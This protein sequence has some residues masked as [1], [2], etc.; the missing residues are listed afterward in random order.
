MRME[1]KSM[2]RWVTEA[3]GAQFAGASAE[4]PRTVME[5]GGWKHLSIAPCAMGW[6]FAPGSFNS[7]DCLCLLS[8]IP[9]EQALRQEGGQSCN[10]LNCMSLVSLSWG[11]PVTSPSAAADIGGELR[12]NDSEGR[13]HGLQ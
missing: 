11:H 1:E 9:S 7:L 10:V 5:D 13:T 2:K 4:L 6:S 12:G 8:G 3:A